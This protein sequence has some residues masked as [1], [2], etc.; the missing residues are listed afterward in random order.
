MI[1][2]QRKGGGTY[3]YFSSNGDNNFLE[4]QS[5]TLTEKT[6]GA[7]PTRKEEYWRGVLKTAIPYGLN[8]VDLFIYL[9]YINLHTIARV[10]FSRERVFISASSISSLSLYVSDVVIVSL[11]LFSSPSSFLLPPLFS[12]LLLLLLFS[13]LTLSLAGGHS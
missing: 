12:L 11:L 3:K 6:D 10:H 5:F 1:G 8:T 2:K 9:I 13:I 4:D 7:D